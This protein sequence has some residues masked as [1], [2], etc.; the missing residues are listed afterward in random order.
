MTI[1][2][3][4]RV[5]LEKPPSLLITNLCVSDLVVGLIA[6]TLASVMAF[7]RYQSWLVPAKMDLVV[8]LV[9]SLSLFVRSGTVVA[10]SC[11]V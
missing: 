9:L 6:A 10:L 5:L 1:F 7:Y 2:R 8:R 3:E 4:S 11:D